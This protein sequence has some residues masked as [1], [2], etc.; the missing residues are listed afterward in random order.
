MKLSLSGFWKALSGTVLVCG[1]LWAAT[2]GYSAEEVNVYSHRHYRIDESINALFTEQTG[3]KVNVVNAQADQLIERLK[4]EGANSPA[5]LLIT[6]DVGRMQRAREDGL[7][8]PLQSEVL[9]QAV[10]E[11]LRDPEG[12]WHPY[13]VRARVFAVATD[14]VKPDEIRNYADLAD[15]KW[16]GRVLVRSASSPYNQSLLASIVA[17]EG[18]D[19]ARAWAKGVVSNMARPPQGGDRDQIKAVAAGLAD[20]AVTNTYYFGLLVNSSDQ[21]E[22][23]L[24]SKI[25]LVFPNQD[26]RGTH[27]NVGVAGVTKH[28]RNLE[29]ARKYL[30]FLV[31]PEVQKII[32]NGSYEYPISLD[33]TLSETHGQWGEF[34]IDSQ[35]FQ[36]L[37]ENQ[38]KAIEIFDE[39]GWK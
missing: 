16:R 2:S 32:A 13:T 10:P 12:Y 14:R 15:R 5:D 17:A 31:S 34:K 18:E 35:T 29:N 33:L 6:V 21:A 22:R 37:G 4:S 9:E 27:V 1:S 26:G 3:I 36:E 11:K 25:T 7:L 28:A 30:E 19:A 38:A 24:A 39:A 8:Q 20:I 23:E